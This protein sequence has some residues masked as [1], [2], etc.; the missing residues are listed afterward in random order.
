MEKENNINVDLVVKHISEKIAQ[1]SR[2]NATLY[3][4]AAAAQERANTLEQ[5]LQNSENEK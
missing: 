3:A 5:K 1:L 4:I 2:E